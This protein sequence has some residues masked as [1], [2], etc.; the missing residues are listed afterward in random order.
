MP[1]EKTVNNNTENE[2]E[3]TKRKWLQK[4]LDSINK[5][6]DENPELFIKIAFGLGTFTVGALKVLLC[7]SSRGYYV[8]SDISEEP[9]KVRHKL[10]NS[11]ILEL[12]ELLVDGRTKGEALDYMGLL[13]KE[14][15]R[16]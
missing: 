12:D 11:E 3:E 14:R 4:R 13:S 15:K 16:K 7:G 2:K 10:T 6:I 8:K 1:N 9:Y 5:F